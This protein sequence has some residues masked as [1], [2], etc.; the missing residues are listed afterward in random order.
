MRGASEDARSVLPRISRPL[1]VLTIASP[2]SR[3]AKPFG[4]QLSI[5]DSCHFDTVLAVVDILTVR[6][7]LLIDVLGGIP[8]LGAGEVC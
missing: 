2:I 4:A 8:E 1:Y 6:V 5:I 7:V 3:G